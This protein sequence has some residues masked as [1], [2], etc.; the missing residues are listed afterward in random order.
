MAAAVT[1]AIRRPADGG[2]TAFA[3]RAAETDRRI[4]AL[5][6]HIDRL[7]AQLLDLSAAM[8]TR[9][10]ASPGDTADVFPRAQANPPEGN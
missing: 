9:T 10:A 4:A 7:H 1:A 3:R 5:H 2:H 8:H 6:T